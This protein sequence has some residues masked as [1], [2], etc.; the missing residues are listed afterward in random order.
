MK[1]FVIVELELVNRYLLLCLLESLDVVRS[2]NLSKPLSGPGSVFIFNFDHYFVYV[3]LLHFSVDRFVI[4]SHA[5]DIGLLPSKTN[6]LVICDIK[7][8]PHRFCDEPSF[9][10]FAE[11]SLDD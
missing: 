5:F 9:V 8:L 3:Q 11:L 7:Y 2:L 4:I 1:Y 10:C 6:L